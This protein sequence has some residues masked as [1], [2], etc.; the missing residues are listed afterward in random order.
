MGYGWESFG[1]FG[2]SLGLHFD[3]LELH[4]GTL[5][6][7][8][9]VLSALWDVALDPSGHFCGKGFKKAPKMDAKME[10]FS[11]RFR[12]FVESGKQCLDCACAVGLGFGPMFSLFGPPLVP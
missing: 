1:H 6:V 8:V 3:T 4:L 7:H 5:V 2:E 10:T 11:M 9:G 12:V